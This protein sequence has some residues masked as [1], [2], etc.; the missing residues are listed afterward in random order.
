VFASLGGIHVTITKEGDMTFTGLTGT[1][2]LSQDAGD[3]LP[4]TLTNYS[5]ADWYVDGKK[6]ATNTTAFTLNAV[7][8][9][10]GT[11][12]LSILVQINGVTYSRQV[13][14]KL[15]NP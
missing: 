2:I 15:T 3:T 12:D 13:E 8:Y 9:R 14:F 11:H 5:G 4:I 1:I 7:D 6:M 10:V